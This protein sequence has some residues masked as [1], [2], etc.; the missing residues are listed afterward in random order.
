M[1]KREIFTSL[2]FQHTLFLKMNILQARVASKMGL[3][4]AYFAFVRREK[5]AGIFI[6][7]GIP[8]GVIASG[9]RDDFGG[10]PPGHMIRLRMLQERHISRWWLFAGDMRAIYA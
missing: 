6:A 1:G 2:S 10:M 5:R 3:I 4:F 7:H 8:A 9:L